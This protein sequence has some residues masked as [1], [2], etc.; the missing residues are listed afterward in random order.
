MTNWQV[1]RWWEL[2]RLLYNAILFVIGIASIL[3]M[4]FLLEKANPASDDNVEPFLGVVAYGFMANLCYTLGWIVELIG[5]RQDE[6]RARV[7]AKKL[8]LMGL[9]FSCLLTSAPF[10]FGLIFWMTHRGH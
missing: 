1:I 10:W 5:R 9:W 7:R 6:A 8:F 4:M 3:G 2:R